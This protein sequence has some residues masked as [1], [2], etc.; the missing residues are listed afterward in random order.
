[1]AKK[2]LLTVDGAHR[3]VVNPLLTVDSVHRRVKKAFVTVGGVQRP[4]WGSSGELVYYDV[5]AHDWL[6][7]AGYGGCAV[8]LEN[9]ALFT[10]G[11]YY[12]A[13][14]EVERYEVTAYDK[15][16]TAVSSPNLY[17]GYEPGITGTAV[18]N[19]ALFLSGN[20]EYIYDEG[21]YD[22]WLGEWIEGSWELLDIEYSLLVERVDDYLSHTSVVLENDPEYLTSTR[23]AA[24]AGGYGIFIGPDKAYAVSSTLTIT[25]V[26]NCSITLD[27]TNHTAV[28]FDDYAL[29][30]EEG[31]GVYQD[32]SSVS[33]VFAYGPTLTLTQLAPFSKTRYDFASTRTTDYALFGG[34]S[35]FSHMEYEWGYDE[36]TGEEFISY[37]WPVYANS[38]HVDVYDKALT[39]RSP[40]YLS[41]PRHQI[42]ATSLKGQALFGPESFRVDDYERPKTPLTVDYF[43]SSLTRNSVVTTK[44]ETWLSG[45]EYECNYHQAASVGDFALFGARRENWGSDGPTG[46]T[47]YED[48]QFYIAYR[49]FE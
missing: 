10:G 49:M 19:N 44:P 48:N 8:S 33:R 47:Y 3:K 30:A 4:C 18:N 17:G 43:D 1:M 26:S 5:M 2:M 40:V 35:E 9:H 11:D 38:S 22:E 42:A 7:D 15:Q 21:Y 23:N 37:E 46:V 45:T 39:R 29:F 24:T 20:E 25:P 41:V 14:H 34:G 36:E 6:S 12:N 31:A 32:D 16:C 28:S 27:R 13:D